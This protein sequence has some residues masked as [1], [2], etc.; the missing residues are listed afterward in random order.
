MAREKGSSTTL[1]VSPPGLNECV[2]DVRWLLRK[3]RTPFTNDRVKPSNGDVREEVVVQA[4]PLAVT[5]S[6]VLP[7]NVDVNVYLETGVFKT[8]H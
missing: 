1:C 6:A 8:Q 5:L 2:Q 7:R 4:S 3:E